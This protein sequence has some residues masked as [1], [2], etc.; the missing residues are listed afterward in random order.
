MD[1]KLI[2]FRKNLG[3]RIKQL[4]EQLNITQLELAARINKDKQV[5]NRYEIEGAN[6]TAYILMALSRALNVDPTT[7]LD[8]SDLK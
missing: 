8:F 2:E 6:P 7:L 5:I 3:R 1:A 4:R